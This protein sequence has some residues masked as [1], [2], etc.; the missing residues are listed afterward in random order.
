M[1]EL[2]K[3]SDPSVMGRCRANKIAWSELQPADREVY[4]RV[5]NRLEEI[6]RAAI[7][8]IKDRYPFEL[9]LTSSFG[10]KNGVRGF[11]PKDLWIAIHHSNAT[12]GIPQI[13]MIV[14]NR[15]VEY[16]FAA[17]IHT[18]DFSSQSYKQQVRNLVPAL[19]SS[20]PAPESA[21]TDQTA[22]K[23][24][25]DRW[26][27]R[28]KTRLDPGPSDFID[29][30]KLLSYL[31]SDDGRQWGAGAACRY[32]T[33]ADLQNQEL[34][35]L[36]DFVNAVEIFAPL[37]ETV[38]VPR[39]QQ[40]P[41]RPDEEPEEAAAEQ[42]SIGLG[43]TLRQIMDL[44]PQIKKTSPYGRR[45]DLWSLFE[46]FCEVGLSK[47]PAFTSD[48]NLSASWS[49]GKGNWAAVPWVAIL[50]RRETTEIQ[51]GRYVVLLFR[52][53]MD[54]VYLTLNQGTTELMNEKPRGEAR[55]FLK[56]RASQYAGSLTVLKEREFFLSD[57]HLAANGWIDLKTSAP[58]P[59][60][61]EYGAIAG[62]FYPKDAMPSDLQLIDDLTAVL[63]AQE[64]LL[65]NQRTHKTWVIAPAENAEQWDDWFRN[66]IT[67]IGWDEI[68]PLDS[69]ETEEQIEAR[70]VE[71][72]GGDVRPLND[73]RACYEFG[74]SVR[75]G[76]TIYAKRG[77]HEIVGVGTVTGPYRRDESRARFKNVRTTR[78]DSR[79]E[80]QL[81]DLMLPIKTLT[82]ITDNAELLRALSKLQAA[83]KPPVIEL[84]RTP[85][86]LDG[87]LA[88]IF[89][90][91]EIFQAIQRVWERKKNVILQGPPGV[92]KTFIAKTLAYSLMGYE[93]ES[94]VEMI[95]F[96][97]SYSYEDFVQG[98]RPTANQFRL[99]EGRFYAFCDRARRDPTNSYVF[100]IDEINRGNLSKIFGEL[101][102]LIEPDKRG[103]KWS[104]PLAYSESSDEKFWIPDNVYLLGM[105]NTA[106]RSLSLVDYALRRRFAFFSLQTMIGSNRFSEHLTQKGVPQELV[107]A[108]TERFVGLN[109]FIADK[110]HSGLG[111]GF[112]IGHSYF[113][114]LDNGGACDF[115]WYQSVLDTQILPLLEEYWFDNDDLLEKWRKKLSGGL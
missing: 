33:A 96:H 95:Q 42:P 89:L 2:I 8:K 62:K 99:K 35:L 77:R 45:K 6:G 71:S 110:N 20:L 91:R 29:F 46:G 85:F 68:G 114:P 43:D 64:Q 70:L 28:K 51:N 27:Y 88:D 7:T 17:S 86:D 103:P 55:K 78:W 44:Y 101:M 79:G 104:V 83:D 74:H 37:L 111:P 36:T 1:Q 102:L 66:G 48:P 49:V 12:L 34:D 113:V 90:P 75:E 61:Y 5:Y 50:D 39:G 63:K 53:S 115:S 19:F 25:T 84:S 52:E 72:R 41:I 15:G 26:V 82:D 47:V 9:S 22:I 18:S 21:L 32:L 98:Y 59:Q 40:L 76:D 112:C 100:I 97:Q 69:Y 65:G 93:D 56:E 67:A 87:A 23:L 30:K 108:I 3:A 10:L 106:D 14:S 109:S 54:G 58:R 24:G 4:E 57:P 94:R 73:A 31:R 107:A 60:D 81:D 11:L 105:M 92:G 16:G 13:Y 38:L 80:W